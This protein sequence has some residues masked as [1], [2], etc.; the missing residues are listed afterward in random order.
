MNFGKW[1]KIEREN[2]LF[3]KQGKWLKILD[4]AG[5]ENVEWKTSGIFRDNENQEGR[6]SEK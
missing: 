3:S 4:V 2:S 1:M 5:I 6:K